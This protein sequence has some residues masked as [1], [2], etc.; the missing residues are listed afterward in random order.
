MG[1]G[2]HRHPRRVDVRQFHGS[3]TIRVA[4]KRD[5]LV[6]TPILQSRLPPR[7]SL[8]GVAPAPPPCAALVPLLPAARLQAQS[9]VPGPAAT[10]L[11]PRPA[12]TAFPQGDPLP[13]IRA[14]GADIDSLPPYSSEPSP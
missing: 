14:S 2:G 12:A 3:G 4:M 11:P 6:D 13:V 7:R 1:A 5:G 10:L 8:T 9:S